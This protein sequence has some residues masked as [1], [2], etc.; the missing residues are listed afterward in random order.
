MSVE[1]ERLTGT[2]LIDRVKEL[3]HEGNVRRIII[4]ND[5]GD[6]IVELPV[7]VGVIGVVFAPALAA[8]GAIAALLSSC[9]I[10][11]I[12]ETAVPRSPATLLEH[13]SP[14]EEKEAFDE[15]IQDEAITAT[16]PSD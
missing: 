6:V 3:I 4:K 8:V 10:E 7:T 15:V 12:R 9:T 13:F 14:E 5:E 11:I 16:S 1:T 2:S